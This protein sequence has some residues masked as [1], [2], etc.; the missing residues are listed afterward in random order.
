MNFY[1]YSFVENN[2]SKYI[3]RLREVIEIPS[4]SALPENRK[5]VI[6]MSRYVTEVSLYFL[7]ID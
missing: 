5:Y 1:V 7:M 3:T 6:E 4:V 2:K